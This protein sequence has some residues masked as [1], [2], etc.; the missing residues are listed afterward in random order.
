MSTRQVVELLVLVALVAL[1]VEIVYVVITGYHC[2][3]GSVCFFVVH[4]SLHLVQSSIYSEA[5]KMAHSRKSIPRRSRMEGAF[6]RVARGLCAPH[7]ATVDTG[8]V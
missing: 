1:V 8:L 3:F 4:D 7:S 5:V 6:V 2:G